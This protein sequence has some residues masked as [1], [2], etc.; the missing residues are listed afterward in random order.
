MKYVCSK[1][2]VH[3]DVIRL[4]EFEIKV[5]FF[6]GEYSYFGLILKE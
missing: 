3:K 6:C 4:E 1:C 5:C 2:A